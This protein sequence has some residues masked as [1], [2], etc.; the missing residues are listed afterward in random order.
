MS[1]KRPMPNNNLNVPRFTARLPVEGSG[2]GVPVDVV[3]E[4]EGARLSDAQ[5]TLRF[6]HAKRTRLIIMVRSRSL[7][8]LMGCQFAIAIAI[9][10]LVVRRQQV[11]MIRAEGDHVVLAPIA[12]VQIEIQ[13]SE[14]T[15]GV[16]R[17]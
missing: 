9:G 8:Q 17:S 14:A 4:V 10:I 1:V 5:S 12:F 3:A 7:D 2:P 6:V 13:S 16:G 15:A 11:G